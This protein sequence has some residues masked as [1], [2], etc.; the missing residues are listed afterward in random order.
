MALCTLK[1]T[2]LHLTISVLL[3]LA[4]WLFSDGGAVYALFMAGFLGAAY[5][6]AAWLAYLKGRGRDVFAFL[7]RD[8]TPAVP[9][10][11]R[12]EK[13]SPSHLRFFRERHAYDDDGGADGAGG[14]I[15]ARCDALSFLICGTVMLA[16]SMLPL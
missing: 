1:K 16:L 7:R 11:Y 15:K 9:Y 10:A 4:V 5:L 13:E 8:K 14:K 12:R 6:L 3:C 2:L